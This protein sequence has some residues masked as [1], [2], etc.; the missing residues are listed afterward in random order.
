MR[1]Y[2]I[3]GIVPFN[4]V[5]YCSCEYLIYFTAI[6]SLGG[7]I[8]S[9]MAN[10]TF[11]YIQDYA[12]E[13]RT[14]L[15]KNIPQISF[16]ELTKING[17]CVEAS[18]TDGHDS[19]DIIRDA[20]LADRIV[21]VPA[22]GFYYPHPH[23]DLFYRK[24]HHTQSFL[25]YGFD[26]KQKIFKIVD[27]NGF[28]WNTDKCCYK[29]EITFKELSACFESVLEQSQNGFSHIKYLYK[30]DSGKTINDAPYFYKDILIDNLRNSKSIIFNGLENI[31][32]V[33]DNIDCFDISKPACFSNKVTSA[34]NMYKMSKITGDKA[35][36][37]ILKEINNK[38]I[39]IEH[40]I[41]KYEIIK[42]TGKEE[43]GLVL[44][45]IYDLEMSFYESFFDSC[46]GKL[47]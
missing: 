15:L 43:I 7:N 5:Y 17:I 13:Y 16:D 9:Y 39:I 2:E 33:I 45:Q 26:S 14:I 42:K 32:A 44:S 40:L 28:E 12:H 8:F 27:V 18:H 36:I 20:L 37:D 31:K 3:P 24:E 6:K 47:I 46:G 30:N 21:I 41:Y 10:D 38:W 19:V 22:D 35:N 23:H 29:H 25:I 34:S 11:A 1:Y 4:D